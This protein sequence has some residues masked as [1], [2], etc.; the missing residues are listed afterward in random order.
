M[1]RLLI[2]FSVLLLTTLTLPVFGQQIITTFAGSGPPDNSPATSAAVGCFRCYLA[3]NSAG[4]Y[5]SSGNRVF[6]IK[7][8][9][10]IFTVAGNSLQGYSGD[11]GPATNATFSQLEV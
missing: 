6:K 10:N 9:G 1:K 4:V 5:V 8:A 3:V 7:P 2:R 11:G